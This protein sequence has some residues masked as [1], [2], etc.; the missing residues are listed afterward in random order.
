MGAADEGVKQGAPSRTSGQIY[1]AVVRS[2]MLYKLETWVMTLL[3]G[4]GLGG[5]HH[6]VFSR[7]TGRQ[8]RKKGDGVWIYPP[9]DAMMAEA[10]LEEVET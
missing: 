3:I 7:M 9:L 8:P 1:L 2:V 6:R 5:F 10:G 4:R